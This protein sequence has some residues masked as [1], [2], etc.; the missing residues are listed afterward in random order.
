MLMAGRRRGPSA[1]L[2][3]LL[4]VFGAGGVSGYYFRDRQQQEKVQDAV[5]NAREEMERASLDAIDRAKRAGGDLRA[6]AEAAAESTRA[7]FRELL[8]GSTE[9]P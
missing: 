3:F 4:F 5:E 1:R 7:A 8:R 2:L 6:G 9:E